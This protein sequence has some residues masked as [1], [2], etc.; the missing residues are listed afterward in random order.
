MRQPL[1]GLVALRAKTPSM[2]HFFGRQAFLSSWVRD[3]IPSSL[4]LPGAQP[5]WETRSA[6]ADQEGCGYAIDHPSDMDS[7]SQ[8][9]YS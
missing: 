4:P 6:S 3:Q 5:G 9:A 8:D 1:T 7:A 2:E